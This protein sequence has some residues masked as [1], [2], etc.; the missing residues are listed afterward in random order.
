MKRHVLLFGFIVIAF[1]AEA[2]LEECQKFPATYA[3]SEP[4]AVA[5]IEAKETQ[6]LAEKLRV[7][8][9]MPKVP[10]GFVNAKWVQFK[11]HIRKGDVVVHF[12]SDQHSWQVL[13]GEEG[14]AI[15]HSDCIV[16]TFRTA[17]N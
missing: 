13:A 15:V 16:E 12:V 2:A 17:M 11:S 4:M 6:D 10:F 9:D 1:K 8:P 7:R 3:I 14:Y 5:E